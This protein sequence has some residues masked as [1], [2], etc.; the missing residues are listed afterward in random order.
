MITAA[1]IISVGALAFLV[2]V[3]TS[4]VKNFI[5]PKFGSIGVQVF[6]FILALIGAFYILYGAAGAI[7][8]VAVA[9]YEVILNKISVFSVGAF[10]SVNPGA[11]RS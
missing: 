3:L 7:F 2:N 11:N 1:S 10:P 9:Y 4:L 8:S 5:Q 6:A